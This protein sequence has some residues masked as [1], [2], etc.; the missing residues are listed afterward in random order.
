[1]RKRE[2]ARVVPASSGAL[3]CGQPSEEEVRPL[4][5]PRLVSAAGCTDQGKRP[6]GK[7]EHRCV[8]CENIYSLE[9]K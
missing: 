9:L 6:Y 8:N 7:C 4:G 5:G 3:V 1:M 2:P